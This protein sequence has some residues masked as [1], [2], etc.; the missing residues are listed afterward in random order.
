[1]ASLLSFDQYQL[2]EMTLPP[3]MIAK[4]ERYQRLA[5]PVS[6]L[7]GKFLLVK[8]LARIGI[9]T[10]APKHLRYN[11]Y[12]R[13]FVPNGPDFNIS[14]SCNVVICA[15]SNRFRGG[16]DVERIYSPLK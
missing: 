15:V 14:H 4:S 7:H 10:N 2:L 16:V 13:P 8:G 12:G 3:E 1:M 5:R 6:V 9:A 11:A